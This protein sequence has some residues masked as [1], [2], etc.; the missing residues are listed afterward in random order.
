MQSVGPR[1]PRLSVSG[2]A[3]AAL[4]AST[5]WACADRA[6]KPSDRKNAVTH[7]GEAG[8]ARQYCLP[9][10]AGPIQVSEDSVGPLALGVSLGRLKAICPAAYYIVSYGEETASPAL[11]FPFEGLTAVAVQD[12]DSLL[13]DRPADGWRVSGTNGILWG[14]VRLTAPWADFRD[15]FAPGIASGENIS[16][17]EHRVTVMF[18][19]HPRVLLV[20]DASPDSVLPDRRAD[21]SRIPA[22]ARIRELDILSSSNPTWQC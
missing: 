8:P 14:R 15:A 13:L 18:C 17:G 4:V 10:A 12:Q 5:L 3:L 9:A 2:G 11:A 6:A 20:L 19:A 7:Q 16:I 1:I 21:L 22:S